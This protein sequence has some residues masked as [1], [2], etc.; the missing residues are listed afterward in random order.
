MTKHQISPSVLVLLLS[1]FLALAQPGPI[2]PGPPGAGQGIISGQVYDQDLSVPIE[3]ANVVL[4]RQ[5]DSSQVTGTVTDAQ[6][7]YRLTGVPAG[8]FYIDVSFIGY[9]PRRIENIQLA[10]AAQIDLGRIQLRQTVLA[11]KGVEAT[12]ERPA[13]SYQID[14]K[15]IDVSRLATAASGT[16]V[17]VLENAPSVKVDAEGN[18][19][20]RGSQ[21]FTVLIDNRPSPLDGSEALQQIPAATIDRIEIITNPSARYD[22]EGVSGIIN[23]IL[24][25]QRQSGLSG[26][27]SADGGW[28][29]R[30]G[31]SLLLSLRTDRLNLFGGGNFNLGRFPGTR[32]TDVRTWSDSAPDT[33]RSFSDGS[34]IRQHRFWGL[35]AGGEYRW[36][37]KVRTSLNLNYGSR[38]FGSGQDASYRRWAA[39]GAN[40]T[41]VQLSRDTSHHGGDFIAANLDH[42]HGLAGPEGHQLAIAVSYR[43]MYG[44]ERS[45]SILLDSLADTIISGRQDRQSG[46]RQPVD[47]KLDYTLPLRKEDKLEAGSATALHNAL[48]RQEVW[49]YS[50]V[51]DSFEFRPEYGYLV[52]YAELRQ[53]FYAQYAGKFGRLGLQPALRVEYADRVVDAGDSGRFAFRRWDVFPT[54]HASYE[55]PA[56][57]QVMASYTRRIQRQRGW[58][59][60]PFTTRMDAYNLRRGNPDLRPEVTDAFEAGWQRSFGESRVSLEGYYRVTNDKVERIRTVYAPGV[61]LHTAANVGKDY[62]FGAEATS[63]L[64]LARW[65]NL[66]LTG[67]VFNYRV[68]GTVAGADF[69]TSR[70]RWEGRAST[71]IRLPTQTRI[72]LSARYE[73]PEISAQEAEPGRLWT[74]AAIRQAFLNRQLVLT[75]SARDLL[76]TAAWESESR[77][78]GFYNYFKFRRQSPSVSLNLV[79]NFNNYRPERRQPVETG[80]DELGTGSQGEFGE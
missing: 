75:L 35:R 44:N 67:D 24:K 62:S 65:L 48:S 34:G 61:I 54:L 42:I 22:P 16:A 59:L 49:E 23:V 78:Q 66:D 13:L 28:P 12:A 47:L 3:Y 39:P 1:S 4:Y 29:V 58:E 11:V 14:K 64:V 60:W 26:M 68:K 30:T 41:L 77:G 9:E 56:G 25:K 19:T 37:G 51:S 57:H 17:D 36:T 69:D 32:L 8:R 40:D 7:R 27:A 43:R 18:V 15:V 6:G 72:T 63:T 52:N 80:T 31:T 53:A 74:D 45:T 5:R 20:L 79:W 10:T 76:G 33:I 73:S 46:P 2:P 21:N 38:G 70:F 71:E 50:P 55:L